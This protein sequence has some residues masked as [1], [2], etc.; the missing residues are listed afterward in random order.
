M[1]FSLLFSCRLM[2][3]LQR[4]YDPVLA[5][6]WFKLYWRLVGNVL[7][8]VFGWGRRR[9]SRIISNQI[10]SP[11]LNLRLYALPSLHGVS[12][13]TILHVYSYCTNRSTPVNG[14]FGN[15]NIYNRHLLTKIST[16][17]TSNTSH[18]EWSLEVVSRRQVH[19]HRD[20]LSK[21]ARRQWHQNMVPP[22]AAPERLGPRRALL[23]QL[24]PD[25]Y[26]HRLALPVISA[27]PSPSPAKCPSRNRNSETVPC[28]PC[29]RIQT[30]RHTRIGQSA[31]LAYSCKEGIASTSGIPRGIHRTPTLAHRTSANAPRRR[32]V[33]TEMAVPESPALALKTGEMTTLVKEG[34]VPPSP[35]GTAQ[36][37]VDEKSAKYDLKRCGASLA[38]LH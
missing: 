21:P 34:S 13:C 32:A 26:R 30:I 22:R 24:A 15:L 33:P 27:A 20:S 1:S 36:S 11:N 19:S 25:A 4:C 16:I 10:W 5:I 18:G 23:D 12:F 3:L 2:S 38:S 28:T 35:G 37:S 6:P 7:K 31:S 9:A 8:G 14:D 29:Q 17:D